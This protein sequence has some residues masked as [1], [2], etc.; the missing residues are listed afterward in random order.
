MEIEI[1]TYEEAEREA[2][3]KPVPPGTYHLQITE[4]E[5][6]MGTNS[7]NPYINFRMDLVGNAEYNGRVVF[8][9]VP[10]TQR[11]VGLLIQFAK[12]IDVKWE[13]RFN[14]EEFIAAA[15]GRELDAD[16]VIEVLDPNTGK[17]KRVT[18]AEAEDYDKPQNKIAKVIVPKS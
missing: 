9:V 13:G 4:G 8:H 6:K 7:G 16:I 11:A 3:I 5:I 18:A 10:L 2:R 1:G 14:P 12:A 15:K 17:N